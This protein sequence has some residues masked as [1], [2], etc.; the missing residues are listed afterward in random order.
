MSEKSAEDYVWYVMD[1]SG[2]YFSV[3]GARL[4]RLDRE[5]EKSLQEGE[6]LED[7]DSDH[8]DCWNLD[9]VLS[10]TDAYPLPTDDEE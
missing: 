8:M 4:V 9:F 10:A 7:I 3:E 1:E 6:E 5:G 2:T